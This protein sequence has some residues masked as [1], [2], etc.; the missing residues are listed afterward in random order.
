M[1]TNKIFHYRISS[2]NY[3][4]HKHILEYLIY[5]MILCFPS[6]FKSGFLMNFCKLNRFKH[7]W[8]D[9]MYI[10]YIYIYVCVCVCVCVCVLLLFFNMRIE[11]TMNL[12]SRDF[13]EDIL[14][15]FCHVLKAYCLKLTLP[16]LRKKLRCFYGCPARSGI[17]NLFMD[18]W[19][20]CCSSRFPTTI[21]LIPLGR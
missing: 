8:K 7:D 5:L 1:A 15:F 19:S 4:T 17:A 2:L 6:C 16:G 10:L 14:R 3:I 18:Y 21:L 11:E 13:E 12:L 20:V 9:H